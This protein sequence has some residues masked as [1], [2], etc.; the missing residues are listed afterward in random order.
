MFISPLSQSSLQQIHD[1]PSVIAV[2][3][4]RLLTLQCYTYCTAIAVRFDTGADCSL[5]TERAYLKLK[6]LYKLPLSPC[7]E[8]SG[9]RLVTVVSVGSD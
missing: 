4:S 8:G 9:G 6:Q 2:A 5:L 3:D 7:I 1:V